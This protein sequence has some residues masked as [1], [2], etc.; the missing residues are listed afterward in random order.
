MMA[1]SGSMT[2]FRCCSRSGNDVGLGGLRRQVRDVGDGAVGEAQPGRA[3]AQVAPEVEGEGG[4]LG[5]LRVGSDQAEAADQSIPSEGAEQH[6]QARVGEQRVAL[7]L[8]L[9]LELEGADVEAVEIHVVDGAHGG[10]PGLG[11]RRVRTPA[12]VATPATARQ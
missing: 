7:L 4:W 11:R 3:G 5:R 12:T 2:P 10:R 8:G 9:R 6:G 1:L